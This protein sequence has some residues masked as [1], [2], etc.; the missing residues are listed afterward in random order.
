MARFTKENFHNIQLIFEERTGVEL[1]PRKWVPAKK[2]VFLAAVLVLCFGLTAFTYPLFS[3]LDGDQLSLS[4]RYE[5]NGIV[6]INVVNGSEK[7]LEFQKQLKLISWRDGEVEPLE[8]EVIFENTAF[9]PHSSGTMTV[10]L[11]QAYPMEQIE[12]EAAPNGYYLLLTNQ[13]FL[14]GQDWICSFLFDFAPKKESEETK[15]ENVAL[16]SQNLDGIQES[17]RFYFEDHYLDEVPAWNSV[18]GEYL[19]KVQAILR[20]QTGF[21]VHSVDPLLVLDDPKNEILDASLPEDMQYQLVTQ[22]HF[23]MDSFNRI[24]CSMFPGEGQDCALTLCVPIPQ[25]KGQVDGG[26]GGFYVRYFFTYPTVELQQ[27]NA[28]TFIYGRILNFEDIEP[29]MVYEDE[30]YTVYDMTHLFFTDLDTYI[31][32]FLGAYSGQTYMDEQ[33]RQRIHN[34][35]DY[36]GDREKLSFHYVIDPRSQN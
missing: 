36:Y 20:E 17:L 2:L 8:G 5:G 12:Q 1:T 27:E 22:N 35:Y 11:S 25:Y 31:D 13:D 18:N 10:D 15:S 23:T 34:V 30:L 21:F 29:Y 9:E 32:D 3:P 14:F 16:A 24:V 28:Y 6:S 4:G 19:E 26:N 7:K 33:V